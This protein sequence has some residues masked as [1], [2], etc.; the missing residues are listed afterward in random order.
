M[1]GTAVHVFADAS[2][3]NKAIAGDIFHYIGTQEGQVAWATIVGAADPAQFA[4]AIE[5][6]DMAE[7][8]R[9]AL[10]MFTEQVRVGPSEIVRN[11]ETA[12]VNLEL[13]PVTPSLAE[14]AQGIY[15][16][17]IDDIEGA[18]PGP[19]RDRSNEAELDRAIAAAVEKGANVSRDD[20]VF[21]NWDPTARLWR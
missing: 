14:I 5:E 1:V 3:A 11:S 2:D 12:A 18:S 7:L 16:D 10:I 21:P 4:S 13:R 6:A 17:Q 15:T 9:K 19:L 8:E 20:Y